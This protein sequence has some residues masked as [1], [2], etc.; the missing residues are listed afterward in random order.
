MG[1]RS[2]EVFLERERNSKFRREKVIAEEIAMLVPRR[3]V[4]RYYFYY[5]YYFFLLFCYIKFS[6]VICYIRFYYIIDFVD[7]LTRSNLFFF[8]CPLFLPIHSCVSYGPRMLE[9]LVPIKKKKGF[10]KWGR[11]ISKNSQK[12]KRKGEK[13]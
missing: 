2:V 4:E 5:F 12:K 11:E 6:V 13:R 3:W 1:L 8:F 9:P 7:L 10:R